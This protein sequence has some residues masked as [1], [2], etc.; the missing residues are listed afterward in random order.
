MVS[1]NMHTDWNGELSKSYLQTSEQV[2]SLPENKQPAL[3]AL[4]DEVEHIAESRP[5]TMSLRRLNEW[6]TGTRFE[7]SWNL[8]HQVQLELLATAPLP[9]MQELFEI[10]LEHGQTLPANDPAR[11]Q[12]VNFINEWKP[13]PLRDE[14]IQGGR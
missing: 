14:D 5:R 4:L 2:R 10:V 1:I 6:W 9:L 3:R 13:G 12:L 11:T 7:A 8:L